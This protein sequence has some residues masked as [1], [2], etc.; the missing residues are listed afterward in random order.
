MNDEMNIEEHLRLYKEAAAAFDFTK[1][2]AQ[3][4]L[5]IGQHFLNKM[6]P[7]IATSHLETAFK[8]YNELGLYD[9]ANKARIV[10]GIS[11]GQE[12]LDEYIDLI[13]R[14]G[15]ADQEAI[16]TIC[17]W[18]NR[19]SLFWVE[20]KPEVIVSEE[21]SEL[22]AKSLEEMISPSLSTITDA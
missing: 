12:V 2:L 22:E 18:K 16:L 17:Q 10:A 1:E 13:L 19:R 21:L 4:H 15:M 9:D 20:K 11:K 3:A 5:C 6:R 14:C 7:D 8:L